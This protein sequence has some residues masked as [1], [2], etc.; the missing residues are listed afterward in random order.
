IFFFA[1]ANLSVN[2]NAGVLTVTV[3]LQTPAEQTVRVRYETVA[4]SALPGVD[5]IATSGQLTFAVGE[6]QKTFT[7]VIIADDLYEPAETFTLR[8]FN[9]ENGSIGI[10]NTTTVTII[11]T[12]PPPEIS[13]DSAV[14]IANESTGSVAVTVRLNRVSA[15][16]ARVS[17]TITGTASFA[18]HGLRDGTIVFPAGTRAARLLIPIVDDPEAENDETVVITLNSPVDATLGSPRTHTLTIQDND[19]AG[20]VVQPSLI[21]VAEGGPDGTYTIRLNSRPTAPVTI[22]LSGVQVMTDPAILTFTPANWSTPQT[23][24]VQAIDDQVA[25]PTPHPGSVSH[26]STSA[27][28]FYQGLS[29]PTLAV[30]IADNDTAGI[31]TLPFSLTVA[32]GGPAVNYQ[33]RLATQPTANVVLA[34]TPSNQVLLNGQ[35]IPAP[36]TLTFTPA[37]WNVP[38]TVSVL[39]VDD[40]ID[41]GIS[42]VVQIAHAASSTEPF[43]NGLTA[44]VAVTVID[45]D[46][47][48]IVL[49]P[50]NLILTEGETGTYTVRLNSQP[51]AAVTVQLTPEFVAPISPLVTSNGQV[52]LN[53]QPTLTLTFTPA[54]WNT[55]QTVSVQVIDDQIDETLDPA[56]TYL[57]HVR[58]TAS[59]AGDAIY[60]ELPP[61]LLPV[62]IVENDVATLILT[63]A[64]LTVA[65]GGPAVTYT[66]RL[67]TQPLAPV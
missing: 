11:D 36:I 20:I 45:N 61:V 50:S 48:G 1:N 17:Y 37:N 14:S 58:H 40:Q 38:Q 42:E 7:V 9:P 32:E 67:A 5:Y 19:Q 56:T 43:Y 26:T 23:V 4:G 64:S 13:F 8:L 47:A 28:P 22:T 34:I 66:A 33:V 15:V 10:P 55:P 18:D 63:P 6:Q 41:E 57:V 31:I 12:S 16:D 60:N 44:N 2:E 46:L 49:A 24:I 29:L 53:G 59:S 3:R 21:D 30:R 35:P 54:N 62:T 39:A 27:D 65:E 51:V 52:L 25:E